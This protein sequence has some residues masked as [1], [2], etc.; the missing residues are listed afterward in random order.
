MKKIAAF[1]FLLS[2]MTFILGQVLY[3]PKPKISNEFVALIEKAHNKTAF[4]KHK[5]LAFD[6]EVT[7]GGKPNLKATVT[8]QT[9]SGKIKL[10]YGNGVVVYFDG[11]NVFLTPSVSDYKRARFDVL[12]FQ[13]FFFA[14][15]K[16]RDNGV[17]DRKSTRL[18]YSH[19]GIS[20]MPSSA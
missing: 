14:P 10:D 17:S 20:R 9:N 5:A 19:G 7:W 6:I 3:N 16:L 12:T 18:N 13:Y 11:K 15:F 1:I 8:S 2:P 4:L